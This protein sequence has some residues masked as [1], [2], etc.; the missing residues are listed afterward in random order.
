MA[1]YYELAQYFEVNP[2]PN[3]AGC[4]NSHREEPGVVFPGIEPAEASY[5]FIGVSSLYEAL[6]SAH[7]LTP[8]KVKALLSE[9]DTESGKVSALQ[10]EVTLLKERLQ[11]FD[12]FIAAAEKA[13]LMVPAFE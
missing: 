5:C 4:L 10:T 11:R 2:D 9:A 1:E 3:F 7:G 13:G 8:K 6:A 12:D